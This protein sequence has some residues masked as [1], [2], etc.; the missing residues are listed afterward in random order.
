[1]VKPDRILLRSSPSEDTSPEMGLLL[2]HA[3]A[4][5]Y[6][7]VVIARDLM[8]SSTMMKEALVAGL[9]SSGADVIDLGC[10]SAPVAAM[11]AKHGDCAVYITE[12]REYGLIS[13]Y[14]LMNPNG[15]LFRKDQIRHLDKI[16]TEK[17]EMPDYRHLG[18]VRTYNFATEE[19]NRRLLS[20]LKSPA[21][22][23][24]VLDCSCGVSADSAPQVLN[25]MGADVISI[26][27]QRDR[28]FIS[29]PMDMTEAEHR[30]VRQFVESDPG[31]IG[32]VLNR[33]G[34]LAT[35]LDE[36]GEI[37]EDEKVLAL[38]VMFL[39][40]KR[41]VVPV[42]MTSLVEDAFWGRIDVGMI[43][44][45]DEAPAEERQFIRAPMDAGLI[46]DAVASN[47]ADIG[48]YEGGIIFG[49]ISMMSDGIYTS[50][51]VAQMSA[52]NSLYRMCEDL[53]EYYRDS[54]MFRFECTKDEFSRML[55]EKLSAMKCENI[56]HTDGWRVKMDGGWFMVT[57][58]EDNDQ[59]VVVLAESTDRAYLI[60]LMEIAGDMVDE[61]S[62]GQ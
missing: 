33:V 41:M 43:T 31:T 5:D 30:N 56:E 28:N 9:T 11:M 1:M 47:G 26:N 18:N 50:A 39:K 57:F 51:V 36:K 42:D 37:M 32:V 16:F 6:K 22:S 59:N 45:F 35:I 15:S 12:Y 19:Y 46:C 52:E 2:G 27:A 53:P 10:T 48:F 25:G 8:K 55:N 17:Q 20:I 34:T 60:G 61:C 13:G 38:I 21:G 44:P 7:R 24:L 49:D 58:D 23:S 40:P 3:L 14:L 4:M 54:K 62:K 29:R